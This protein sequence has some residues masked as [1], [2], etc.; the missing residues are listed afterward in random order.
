MCP[1]QVCPG[2]LTPGMPAFTRSTLPSLTLI[3]AVCAHQVCP[4]VA[5]SWHACIRHEGQQLAR[6]QPLDEG[7][8]T[9]SLVE[10]VIADLTANGTG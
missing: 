10:R 6:S 7:G 5:H 3:T 2:S 9:G 1:H 8:S 4:R